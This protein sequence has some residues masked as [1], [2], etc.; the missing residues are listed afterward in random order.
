VKRELV[1]VTWND[2]VEHPDGEREPRHEPAVQITAGFL[3]KRDRRGISIATELNDDDG[4]GW[5]GENFIPAGMIVSVRRTG[6]KR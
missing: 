1:V 3:L 6:L 5:R 4:T 2:A